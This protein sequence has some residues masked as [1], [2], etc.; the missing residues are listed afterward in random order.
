MLIDIEWNLGKSTPVLKMVYKLAK[1]AARSPI[2]TKD[3]GYRPGKLSRHRTEGGD[4]ATMFPANNQEL[5]IRI[6][7]HTTAGKDDC[8]V[9]FTVFSEKENK[10]MQKR[11]A[12]VIGLDRGEIHRHRC[13][14]VRF[15]D[16]PSY[17]IFKIVDGLEKCPKPRRPLMVPCLSGYCR[18]LVSI[19]CPFL[20]STR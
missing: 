11:V 19:W 8:K 15:N 18:F 10:F 12:Y 3:V 7:A 4:A 13:Y 20:K 6:Y 5:L 17:P 2:K 1:A 14:K 16:I 9:S